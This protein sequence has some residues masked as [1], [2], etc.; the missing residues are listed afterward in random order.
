M[1]DFKRRVPSTSGELKE[2]MAKL[3]KNIGHV[4]SVTVNES[5]AHLEIDLDRMANSLGGT[6][7]MYMPLL[8]SKLHVAKELV[9]R[10]IRSGR[11]GYPPSDTDVEQL[12]SF[13]DQ[14]AG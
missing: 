13:I 10:M 2:H 14:H 1:S 3:F 7:D 4:N 11:G 9:E 6:P 8:R 5:N 12:F